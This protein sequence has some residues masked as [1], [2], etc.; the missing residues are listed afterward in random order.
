MFRRT[1]HLSTKDAGSIYRD[2][3][4]FCSK[5]NIHL[6]LTSENP[7]TIHLDEMLELMNDFSYSI[8]CSNVSNFYTNTYF[9]QR[10]FREFKNSRNILDKLSRTKDLFKMI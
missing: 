6:Q 10:N 5:K 3:L 2:V 1:L 8:K 9:N 7:L 4:R